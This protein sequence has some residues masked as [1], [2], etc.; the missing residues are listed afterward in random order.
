MPSG[1]ET[2]IKFWEDD[3]ICDDE[4]KDGECE[5]C[6]CSEVCDS[7]TNFLLNKG[8]L[9]DAGD[10]SRILNEE[11]SIVNNYLYESDM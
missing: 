10:G 5:G 3:S 1:L 11:N 6:A 8:L 4:C 2:L 7:V 9:K